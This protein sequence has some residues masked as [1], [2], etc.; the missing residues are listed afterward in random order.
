MTLV[1]LAV[2]AFAATIYPVSAIDVDTTSLITVTPN[3]SGVY[4]TVQVIFQIDKVSPSISSISG[5]PGQD[6]FT[7]FKVNIVKPD[8]TIINLPET[9]SYTVTAG[10]QAW[11]TYTPD[12]VG[13]YIFE[14][15][16]P[17]QTIISTRPS[18]TFPVPGEYYFKPSSGSTTLV[19]QE[20]PIMGYTGSPPLPTDPWT[21]PI[22]S[23]NKGWWQIADD[24]LLPAYDYPTAAPWGQTYWARYNSAPESPHVLWK[25]PLYFGGIVGG[26]FEDR[27]FYSGLT[28]EE[29][30]PQAIIQQGRI[31]Y[32]DH[33]ATSGGILGGDFYGS[34]IL[35]LYT[36]E[37][38]VFLDG[39]T[40][41][42]AQNLLYDSGN[43]HGVLPYL[44]DKNGS[45]WDMYDAFSARKILSITDVPSGLQTVGP[46]GEILVYGF[47]GS[48]GDRYYWLWNSTKC[49][50]GSPVFGAP[51]IP[52]IEYSEV[53]NPRTGSVIPGMAGI[54]WNASIPTLTENVIGL[55]T[56][57]FVGLGYQIGDPDNNGFLLA[58]YLDRTDYP[59]V[60][61][62]T[63]Y[64]ATLN[65]QTDGTYPNSTSHLWTANRTDTYAALGLQKLGYEGIGPDR[66]FAQYSED[67]LKFHGYSIETGAKLWE[68]ETLTSGFA[69]Y[70]YAYRVANGFLYEGGFDGVL[71]AYYANN[72]SLAWEHS[73]GL[74]GYENAWGTYPIYTGFTIADGKIYVIHR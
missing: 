71:R 2:V 10:S 14:V 49:I 17:G 26:Q 59:H 50:G 70:T 12:Q 65:K 74:A 9:G 25:K 45:T 5:G 62:H 42:F 16:F 66:V 15:T 3:P 60:Y 20:E 72:G 47:S 54:Q 56:P 63:A 40:I 32:V 53:W 8:N 37:E 64:P 55:E 48:P 11:F 34:R 38:I 35:N 58:A 24:W 22:Y 51:N 46:K 31:I 18:F 1:M 30:F 6:F 21:R 27:S 68:T 23:E 43:E 36:G 57:Q 73:Q 19:V 29:F 69:V 33:G 67:T 61:V 28:Y 44:W 52:G 7:G 13:T 41:D 39:I 4:Q